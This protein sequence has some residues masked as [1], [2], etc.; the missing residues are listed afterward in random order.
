ML[1]IPP[2][3]EK[4][5]ALIYENQGNGIPNDENRVHEKRTLINVP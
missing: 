2:T 4:I 1:N 3:L 5:I